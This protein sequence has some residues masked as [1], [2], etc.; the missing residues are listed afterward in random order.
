MKKYRV[1]TDVIIT[2][3]KEIEA[4]SFD[5]ARSKMENETI[6][7][8]DLRKGTRGDEIITCAE[9]DDGKFHTYI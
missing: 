2:V 7:D 6:T 8:E 4:A 5:E 9:S 1:F 3:E